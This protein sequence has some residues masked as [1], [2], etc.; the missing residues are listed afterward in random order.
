MKLNQLGWTALLVAGLF[1]GGLAQAAEKKDLVLTGDAKCTRCHDETESYPVLAIG[2]TRHGVKTDARLPGCTGCHGES[3]THINKPEGQ[4]ERPKPELPFGKGT[5]RNVEGH[6][7]V[8]AS[9]HKGGKFIHWQ[10]SIHSARDVPCTSCHQLHTVHDKVRDRSTQPQVCFTCHKE[11]RNLVTKPS[12]HPILEGKVVCSDCHASHGSAGPRLM[13]RDSVADTCFTC[14]MEKRGAFLRKHEPA[15]DCTAC[16][17]PHGSTV[18]NLLKMRAP[19]LCQECHEPSSHQGGIPGFANST[20]TT[21]MGR[22]ITNARSCLNCHT[23]IHGSNNP[24][25]VSN[26]RTFRR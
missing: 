9:C 11:Q 13:V 20:G 14:H 17:N 19:L 12:H 8:C 16:H 15:D 22:G 23:S 18:E 5:A 24:A 3:E 6:N 25:N 7:A 4:V 10:D 21:S 2:K 1:V 26:E